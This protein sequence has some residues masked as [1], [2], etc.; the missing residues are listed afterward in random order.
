MHFKFHT[1]RVGHGEPCKTILLFWRWV[2]QTRLGRSNATQSDVHLVECL[3][4]STKV[5]YQVHYPDP[6][7]HPK[8]HIAAE[9]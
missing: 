1:E 8:L 5:H 9:K 2:V 3:P 6:P 4:E 7:F